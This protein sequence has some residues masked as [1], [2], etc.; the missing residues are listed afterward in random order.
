MVLMFCCTSDL[1]RMQTEKERT[2]VQLTVDTPRE[3]ADDLL[4]FPNIT[5]VIKQKQ[6]SLCC[7]SV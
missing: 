1:M 5:S 2:V 4:A 7:P 6:L 3:K